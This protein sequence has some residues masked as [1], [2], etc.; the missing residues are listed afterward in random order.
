MVESAI[1]GGLDRDR[2]QR[3]LSAWFAR[4]ELRCL[5]LLPRL[6]RVHPLTDGRRHL[7]HRQDTHFNRRGHEV[8]GE[9]L[10]EEVRRRQGP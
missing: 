5:D 9:A 3:M 4:N 7:Y 1:P 8:A 10:A 2:P 6:R